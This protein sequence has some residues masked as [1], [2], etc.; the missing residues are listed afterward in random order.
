MTSAYALPLDLSTTDQDDFNAAV[1]N[2]IEALKIL[3]GSALASPV[4]NYF[5][6]DSS[7]NQLKKRNAANGAD[8]VLFPNTEAANG[9]LLGTSGGTLTGDL[10]FG[11]FKGTNL[12]APSA[13]GDALRWQ[14]LLR[15]EKQIGRLYNVDGFPSG[16][17]ASGEVSMF[18]ATHAIT[19]TTARF[20]VDVTNTFNSTDYYT[21]KL[22]NVT[23]GNIIAT[24]SLQSVAVVA[25]TSIDM[26]S[27][28]NAN[29][30]LGDV[31]DIRIENTL[32]PTAFL[33]AK[34]EI[35]F[36]YKNQ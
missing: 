22:K 15:L 4:A 9:G 28:S 23:T 36:D 27:I 30:S 24:K 17:G 1:Q 3:H 5:W 20:T 18:C 6:F 11:G 19:V 29:V 31:L 34:C 21:I 33:T 26:G 13:N 14:D 10:N 7:T 35:A 16:S 8:V 2:S 32:N 25:R 12:G